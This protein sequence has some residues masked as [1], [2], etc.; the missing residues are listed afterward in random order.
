MSAGYT[1]FHFTGVFSVKSR[2][3]ASSM[4]Q[5]CAL[6]CTG[7]DDSENYNQLSAV[8]ARALPN[9]GLVAAFRIDNAFTTIDDDYPRHFRTIANQKLSRLSENAWEA[10]SNLTHE[11]VRKETGETGLK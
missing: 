9:R 1:P 11:L 2:R 8:E 4:I 6:A 5:V 7:I 10:I 3:Y